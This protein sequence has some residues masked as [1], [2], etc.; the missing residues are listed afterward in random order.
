MQ[1]KLQNSV[2]NRRKKYLNSKGETSGEECK[3]RE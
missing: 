2:E 1:S 3:V